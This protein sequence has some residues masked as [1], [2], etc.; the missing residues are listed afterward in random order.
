VGEISETEDGQISSSAPSFDG[1]I[2]GMVKDKP[3][4]KAKDVDDDSE[5]SDFDLA[6]K[7]GK[8]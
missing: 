3:K 5:E 2:V 6:K 4:A 7:G 8:G 1:K